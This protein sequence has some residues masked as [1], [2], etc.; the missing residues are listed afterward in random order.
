MFRN[1]LQNAIRDVLQF[2]KFD[3]YPRRE[4][5]GVLEDSVELKSRHI[6]Y[7]VNVSYTEVDNKIQ[8]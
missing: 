7:L 4:L 5:K 2:L 6:S 1:I 3:Y 8:Y